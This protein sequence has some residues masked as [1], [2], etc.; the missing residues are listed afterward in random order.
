[1]ESFKNYRIVRLYWILIIVMSFFQSALAENMN[2][3]GQVYVSSLPDNASV[4]LTGGCKLIIDQN[5]RL[6]NINGNY[7]LTI[8]GQE[9]YTLTM[10]NAGRVINV[11]NL[12]IQS[13]NLV[14]TGGNN[15]AIYGESGFINIFDS[16]VVV[17]AVTGIWAKNN[18][19]INSASEVVIKAG[20]DALKS[21]EGSVYTNGKISITSNDGDGINAD[22]DVV[23]N[24]GTVS[25]DAARDA[26][27]SRHG[28][29]S[30]TDQS[31]KAEAYG[32]R[33]IYAPEGDIYLNGTIK[34]KSGNETAIKTNKGKVTIDGDVSVSHGASGI[35]SCQDMIING[36]ASVSSDLLAVYCTKGS[37]IING[38]VNAIS[39]HNNAIEAS[40]SVSI[41]S[42]QD[43]WV[44]A[45]AP[46]GRS[47]IRASN[48]DVNINSGN[49]Q[50]YAGTGIYADNAIN[51][52]GGY[53]MANCQNKSLNGIISIDSPLS[54]LAPANGAV[55]EK[56][57]VDANGT[58]AKYVEISI[59]PL[60]GTVN[61]DTANPV[62]GSWVRYTL[63]GVVNKLYSNNVALTTQWQRSAATMTGWE[64]V[65]GDTDSNG[66]PVYIVNT[67][68]LDKY[69]R[70]RITAQGYEGVLY[71]SARKMTKSSCSVDV[72]APTLL[73]SNNQ[74][75]VTNPKSTQEYI[76]LNTKKAVSALTESDWANSQTFDPITQTTLFLGG[77]ADATNYVYTRVKETETAYTG[78]DVRMAS[79]YLGTTTYVQD[80]VM[81]FKRVET[82]G[83]NVLYYVDVEQDDLGAYYVKCGEVYR[84]V[85]TPTPSDATFNG[86]IGSKWL[87]AGLSRASQYG[88][89]Y[90]TRACTTVVDAN[91]YYTTVYFKPQDGT[92]VNYKELRVEYAKGYNDIA[93]DAC[94][95]NIA[96]SL[97]FYKVDNLYSNADLTIGKGETMDGL[98]FTVRPAKSTIRNFAV[99]Q[100]GGQGSAPVIS[101]DTASQT[102]SIDATEAT[103][104][105]F[106][107]SVSVNN[108][109]ASTT[110]TVNVTAPALE[111]LKLLP[112]EVTLDP[113]ATLELTPLLLPYNAEADI[114]WTSYNTSVATVNNGVVT[115]A[116]DADVEATATIRAVAGDKTAFCS[117][118]V[119]GEKY[120]IWVAGTQVTSRN[121]DDVLGDGSVSF[122]GKSTLTL[123]NASIDVGSKAAQGATL[124]IEGI[125]LRLI[126]DNT[127]TSNNYNGLKVSKTVSIEGDGSLTLTGGNCGI[128]LD[129]NG[130]NYNICLTVADSARV[131]AQGG[132]Y[133]IGTEGNMSSGTLVMRG[134]ETELRAKGSTYS[135]FGL[136]SITLEDGQ[137]IVT[138][139]GGRYNPV[140][141]YVVDSNSQPVQDEWVEIEVPLANYNL[142]VK[143][144]Q[145]TSRNKDR[146]GI[147]V[148]GNNEGILEQ[149]RSGSMNVWYDAD[150]NILY[151]KNA[152]IAITG[153]GTNDAI[154]VGLS[155]MGINIEGDCTVANSV[156]NG[157]QFNQSGY[158]CGDGTL[159]IS[160][161]NIGTFISNNSKTLEICGGVHL[162]TQGKYGIYG[163][164]SL[165][166]SLVVSGEE[167]VVKATG[168]T[169]SIGGLTSLSLMDGLSI[170]EPADAVFTDKYVKDANGANV[171]SE[172][173]ISQPVPYVVYDSS[174]LT[175]TFYHDGHRATHIG[176]TETTYDLNAG[177][178]SPGW[179]SDGN[180]ANV[181][182]VV[183]DPS[184][185]DARPTSTCSWFKDMGNMSSII[186][187]GNLNTSEVTDMSWMFSLCWGM[188]TFDLSHFDTQNV[189][190]MSYMF[191]YCEGMTNID[192]SGFDTRNVMYMEGMFYECS[193]LTDL[194]LSSFNTEKVKSFKDMFFDCAGL[195][196]LD[197]SHFDNREAETMN[198]MFS[199]CTSLTNIKLSGFG[200]AHAND[201]NSM[202]SGCSSLTTLDLSSFDTSYLLSAEFMFFGCTS[203][204]TIY[205]GDAWDVS[206][207]EESDAMFAFCTNLVGGQG[208]TYDQAHV[209]KA[210]AHIDGGASNPGYLTEKPAF[211][212]GDVNGD[213]QIT[214]ADVTALVNIILGKDTTGQYNHAAADVNQDNQITI[215][216][217][218]ALVNIIL[219][220]N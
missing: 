108:G 43:G 146:L 36:S 77:T 178:D 124:G 66:R 202:F 203:L 15:T 107:Y 177:N 165:I 148:A 86:I 112:S 96:T 87:V 179:N 173:I 89:Y 55:S 193:A 64:D 136:K 41:N 175:L 140:V 48:G 97:G 13:V 186:G 217:V 162:T 18:I 21:E 117:I 81:D 154:Y 50:S 170:I 12:T 206:D 39:T 195:T 145:V 7:A 164:S 181:T 194:D 57:I 95:V 204:Q 101:F 188:D 5:K 8:Q 4:T 122:D 83:D 111:E 208:T 201:M 218:T 69:L 132:T 129:G 20:I 67:S 82:R 126:G 209:N 9:S 210:Y 199:D 110:V 214:I 1:M 191:N 130:A 215:A 105:T 147:L 99:T 156:N 134:K 19:N 187:M 182:T 11:A 168:S 65:E 42:G 61:L 212:L 26:I 158:I 220:K 123:N 27:Y 31:V 152:S 161:A 59:P 17:N 70:V 102:F 141:K 53:I 22:Q 169:A 138:P 128:I 29:I 68:D 160:A 90:T 113:G 75:R 163:L 143:G 157:I 37:I 185:A 56:T 28:N 198:G 54:I 118:T 109:E 78:T 49:I 62:V 171:T 121:M 135:I 73:V 6:K 32:Y 63:S 167:T 205:V 30:I 211:L 125:T 10:V 103:S 40:Q 207:L 172:V 60:S 119:S 189:T 44:I 58:T 45:W 197:L 16:K 153:S 155:G 14:V 116:D 219:G 176:A 200:T 91:T 180:N 46:S 51:I 92:M 79:I 213:G 100:T 74:V 84:I 216:D 120:D 183:F 190:D 38:N 98:K 25:I 23:I 3:V 35:F 47:G 115:I 94:Q 71:S 139:A 72:E 166:S 150:E 196:S 33:A 149:Y 52:H 131:T 88:S 114:S 93:T 104:G 127:I 144:N 159:L 151:L 76:I 184:F 106:Y 80:V 137:E 192:L 174:T 34:A 142:Y 24:S 85:V 133:G 2:V